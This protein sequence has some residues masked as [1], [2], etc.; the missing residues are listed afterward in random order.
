[1]NSL[2]INPAETF[3]HLKPLSDCIIK[4]QRLEAFLWKKKYIL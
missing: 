3:F 4:A 1:L 2:K